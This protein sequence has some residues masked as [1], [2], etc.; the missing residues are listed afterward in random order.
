LIDPKD[1]CQSF[2]KLNPV[3]TE[4]P[5]N[6]NP[7]AETRKRLKQKRYLNLK[8]QLRE[9]PSFK[10]FN[11]T[12]FY[13]L[14][15]AFLAQMVINNYSLSYLKSAKLILSRYA[16]LLKANGIDTIKNVE[17][18]FWRVFSQSLWG[19]DWSRSYI[20]S[21]QSIL[22]SF[23]HYLHCERLIPENP[24]YHSES[25]KLDKR[26][27]QFLTKEEMKLLLDAPETNNPYGLRDRAIME[28][29]YAT[30][31]RVSELTG[32]KLEDLHLIEKEALVLGK[33]HKERYV[34]WG[35]V[36]SLILDRYLKESRPAL[37][38]DNNSD[39]LFPNYRGNPISKSCIEK[40]VKRYGKMVLGKRVW[41]HLFRH[42]MATHLLDGGAD[43]SVI[44]HLL[45]HA[46][47]NTTQ[48]YASVSQS[49]A[50]EQYLK[51]HPL[52]HQD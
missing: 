29:L 25:I 30:G 10:E 12:D 24:F 15:D 17:R 23:Y 49:H 51:A 13:C 40:L 19:H 8:L 22:K 9:N 35:E 32:L 16:K 26:L 47:L 34:I 18:P 38:G 1:I 48:I 2:G 11:Y 37:L 14:R 4:I 50:K 3:R 28:F 52:A 5:K 39:V 21:Q 20:Y 41:C 44:G 42:T 33:G 6:W 7:L 31:V 36:T 27:P 45:G 46:S 43:I